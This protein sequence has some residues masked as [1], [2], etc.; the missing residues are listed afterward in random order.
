MQVHILMHSANQS[1]QVEW[2]HFVWSAGRQI[3]QRCNISLPDIG[4][5]ESL[6]II[7]TTQVCGR[8]PR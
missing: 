8:D 7:V 1:F 2:P 3:E 5:I 4:T 6:D